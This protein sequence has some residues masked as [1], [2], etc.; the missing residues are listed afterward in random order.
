MG[1]SHFENISLSDMLNLRGVLE[2]INCQWQ[3]S[4]WGLWEFVVPNSKGII[5][6]TKNFFWFRCS[7]FVI[8]MKFWG[9][10]KKKMI[11]IATLFRKLE[12]VKDSVRPLFL[13]N[14]VSEIPLTI[15]ML[16]S[17]KLL[18]NVIQ[19]TFII[20]FHHYGRDSFWKYLP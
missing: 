6:Q 5:F 13:K 1:D 16:K 7:I 20:F 15:N 19:N 14:T 9:F 18:W 3:S 17:P 8:Y 4:C 12:T 10:W 2:H 11:V